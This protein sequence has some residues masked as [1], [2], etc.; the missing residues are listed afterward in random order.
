MPKKG[1]CTPALQRIASRCI[2]NQ[3]TGCV[4]WQGGTSSQ[5]KYPYLPN[6]AGQIVPAYRVAYESAYG[7]IPEGPAP[8]GTRYEIHHRCGVRTCCAA[9]HLQL[10]SHRDHMQIHKLHRAAVRAAKR[11]QPQPTPLVPLTAAAS[12]AA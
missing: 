2:T 5:G 3:A 4:L 9:Q 11:R 8:D 6:D 7:P 12:S 10:V 1:F